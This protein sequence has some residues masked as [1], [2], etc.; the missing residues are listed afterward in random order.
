MQRY[1]MSLEP[2]RTEKRT[3]VVP[4]DE[5]GGDVPE[6]MT[7]VELEEEV[8]EAFVVDGAGEVVA[9][10]GIRGTHVTFTRARLIAALLNIPKLRRCAIE[11]VGPDYIILR[12]SATPAMKYQT[13]GKMEELLPG[14]YKE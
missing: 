1:V 8:A 6:N 14:A 12:D 3:E 10:M 11:A 13:Q 5:A 7:E 4:I 9:D 2:S